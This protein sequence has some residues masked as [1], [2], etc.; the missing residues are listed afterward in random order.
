[1]LWSLSYYVI[2]GHQAT[3][4]IFILLLLKNV[5]SINS[6]WAFIQALI[7]TRSSYFQI[8][9]QLFWSKSQL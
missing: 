2:H 1:M 5:A 8:F 6:Y 7:K 3:T 4:E 9:Q